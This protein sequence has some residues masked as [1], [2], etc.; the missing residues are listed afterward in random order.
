MPC[1]KSSISFSITS[2]SP[3]TRATPS[4]ISRMTPTVCL[5]AAALAPA[6]CASISWTRSAMV[7]YLTLTEPAS[8]ARQPGA[9]AAVEHVA[10]DADPHAADERGIL[11]ERRLQPGAVQSRQVWLRASLRSVVGQR[12]RAFD[13]GPMRVRDRAGPCAETSAS[14]A[15]DPRRPDAA[16]RSAT[17]R[18]R[19]GSSWPSTTHSRKQLARRPSGL[20]GDL[21]RSPQLPGRLF[22]QP[23]MVVGRQHFAGDRRRGL[24]DEPPDFAAQLGE[25]A[26]RDRARSLRAR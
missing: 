10:A 13:D 3:S 15:S 1:P 6:I 2:P 14:T 18:T 22:R 24:H 7:S 26:A 5:A 8:I 23:A 12:R 25:H 4:P 21:H 20:S 19:G 11:A 16:T 9:H 17:C